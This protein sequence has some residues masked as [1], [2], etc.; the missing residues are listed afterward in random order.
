MSGKMGVT[1]KQQRKEKV[2]GDPRGD[3]KVQ[4]HRF[5]KSESVL[6][7]TSNVGGKSHDAWSVGEV[8]GSIPLGERRCLR[9]SNLCSRFHR[10]LT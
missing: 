4:I 6:Y 9:R 3:D 5:G 10:P 7:T 1:E 8:V 2:S